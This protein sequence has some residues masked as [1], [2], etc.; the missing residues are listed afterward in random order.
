MSMLIREP[1]NA[2]LFRE[3][4][5][6]PNSVDPET[7]SKLRDLW[8][9][10]LHLEETL[11]NLLRNSLDIDIDDEFERLDA[12]HNVVNRK[13]FSIYQLSTVLVHENN[14]HRHPPQMM[15]TDLTLIQKYNEELLPSVKSMCLEMNEEESKRITKTTTQGSENP[16]N[17]QTIEVVIPSNKDTIELVTTEKDATPLEDNREPRNDKRSITDDSD[18]NKHDKKRSRNNKHASMIQFHPTH[19]SDSTLPHQLQY[20][21]GLDKDSNADITMMV[22]SGASHIL[23]RQEHAHV[24]KYITISETN[25]PPF[26]NV[27]SAKIGSEFSPIGRG[28]LQIGP[29]CF[30][31]YIFR[32]DEL[33]ESLLGLNPLTKRG[34]SATFTDKT[35]SLHHGP[36]S[37]PILCG[38]KNVNQ[39]SWQVTFQQYRGYPMWDHMSTTGFYDTP[40]DWNAT[41]DYTQKLKSTPDTP[42]TAPESQ[43]VSYL[44]KQRVSEESRT[45]LNH[46]LHALKWRQVRETEFERML[47]SDSILY[48]Y[49]DASHIDPNR[50]RMCL[51]VDNGTQLNPKNLNICDKQLNKTEINR[52]LDT[53]TQS[54]ISTPVKHYVR[55]TDF[56]SERLYRM[57]KRR[58]T[59]PES[60]MQMETAVQPA[61]APKNTIHF[62]EADFYTRAIPTTRYNEL[63]NAI[64]KDTHF[65]K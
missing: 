64:N 62:H 7:Y 20:D 46:V 33:R 37:D 14:Q 8:T 40:H 21:G 13:M 35:F 51:Q 43:R 1:D 22:D 9:Q 41:N 54:P 61:Y 28:L 26:A 39:N 57:K 29:F 16:P 4:D 52:L 18:D 60:S 10:R 45:N 38:S 12:A 5:I 17:E 25:A 3:D 65:R 44:G 47:M 42:T 50:T 27:R 55:Q 36:N 56:R 59:A 24:L 53:M 30:P 32:D 2:I 48:C 19:D 31:A 23:V 15:I 58:Y 11:D 6:P 49:E 34:C 63:L